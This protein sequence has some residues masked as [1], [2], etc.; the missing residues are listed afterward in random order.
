M[1]AIIFDLDG[2]LVDSIDDIAD[3]L[4]AAL[5][6]HGYATPDRALVRTWVGGGARAL[7]A[8]AVS[9]DKVDDVVPTFLA[10][11]ARR[12]V[13]HTRLYDGLAP[14]LDALAAKATLAVLSNKPHALTQAIGAQL[15][16]RWPFARIDGAR[17]GVPM[18][19]APDGALA[20][21]AALGATDCVV[22]GDAVSDLA[23]AR[24]AG[25]MDVAVSWGYRPRAELAAAAPKVLADSPSDLLA[26]V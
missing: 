24:A 15:L 3:A 4:I 18:K 12:P 16:A 26:L 20:I 8:H 19:P 25:M 7:V 22:V 6:E 13:V 21:A 2:T 17:D 14:V 5:G 23:C 9:A 11:Y 1:R 10:C